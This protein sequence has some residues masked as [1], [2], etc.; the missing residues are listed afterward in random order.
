VR[1]RGP[2][3]LLCRRTQPVRLPCMVAHASSAARSH[4][5]RIAVRAKVM[6]GPAPEQLDRAA[7]REVRELSKTVNRSSSCLS[8][9]T[10]TP[11]RSGKAEVDRAPRKE[12]RCCLEDL[13]GATQLPDLPLQPLELLALVTGQPRPRAPQWIKMGIH[14]AGPRRTCQLRTESRHRGER[15][16][17]SCLGLLHRLR[18]PQR[19]SVAPAAEAHRLRDW[20]ADSA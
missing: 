11:G 14:T 4:S 20:N 18:E 6:C 9:L 8:H 7:Q 15:L 17:Q 1:R 3:A 19:G 12:S 2:H 13:V 5:Q 16:R 10:V